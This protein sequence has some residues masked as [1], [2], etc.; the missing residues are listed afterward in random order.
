LSVRQIVYLG[1]DYC[2]KENKTFTDHDN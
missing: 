1:D 2:S